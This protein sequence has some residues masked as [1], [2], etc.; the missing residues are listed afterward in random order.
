MPFGR[1]PVKVSQQSS[2]GTAGPLP[3]ASDPSHKKLHCRWMFLTYAECSLSDEAAFVE[4]LRARLK[5]KHL[6]SAEFYGCREEHT[7]KGVRY[8]VLLDVGKQINWL[9]STARRFLR[10]SDDPLESIKIRGHS[11]K[12][13]TDDFIIKHMEDCEQRADGAAFGR[14]T[15][16]IAV[17]AAARRRRCRECG[18]P[19][20]KYCKAC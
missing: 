1:F 14:L 18:Q 11:P 3:H 12:Q 5:Q 20:T 4:G 15:S 6:T 16:A 19:K 8:H 13:R 2:V 9:V 10:V 17:Q 7:Q